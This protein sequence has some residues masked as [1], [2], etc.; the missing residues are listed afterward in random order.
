MK[1]K[2]VMEKVDGV[3]NTTRG[4]RLEEIEGEVISSEIRNENNLGLNLFLRIKGHSREIRWSQTNNPT[5]I[6]V[7]MKLRGF[8]KP[9]KLDDS[10]YTELRGF[11]LYNGQGEIIQRNISGVGYMFVHNDHAHKT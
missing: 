5:F 9:S 7:G 6:T 3:I 11:E 8:Y 2:S 4:Y 1:M 10:P